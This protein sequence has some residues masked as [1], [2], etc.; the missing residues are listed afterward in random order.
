[1]QQEGEIVSVPQ[2]KKPRVRRDATK[3]DLV[4]HNERITV[5]LQELEI[6]RTTLLG[7]VAMKDREIETL[8][9]KCAVTPCYQT[10]ALI[11]WTVCM[12]GVGLILGMELF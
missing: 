7:T 11:V 8:K 4:R 2:E 5:K 9:D 10:W 12:L 3:A 1:M 6:E